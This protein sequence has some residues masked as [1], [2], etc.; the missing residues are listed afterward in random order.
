MNLNRTYAPYVR[1]EVDY[2]MIFMGRDLVP[3]LPR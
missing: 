1:A 2:L 3:P